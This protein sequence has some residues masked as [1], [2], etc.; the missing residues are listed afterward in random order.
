MPYTP[1]E[2]P[3]DGI[4]VYYS[5]E[6]L[7]FLV[8]PQNFEKKILKEASMPKSGES[9]YESDKSQ[10]NHQSSLSPAL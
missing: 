3:M 2:I 4:I 7:Q 9:S 1:S 6:I 10:Q 5:P 8:H